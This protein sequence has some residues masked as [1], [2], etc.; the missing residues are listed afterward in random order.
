MSN[1]VEHRRFSKFDAAGRNNKFWNI[2]LYENG[3]VEV[4]FGPQGKDGQHKT[5]PAGHPKSG[6]HGFDKYIKEK[7]GPKKGYTENKVL[8]ATEENGHLSKHALAEKAVKDMSADQ[9]ELRSLIKYFADVN[10]HN[11][12]KA[13]GGKITYDTSSGTFKT[14]QG[15]ITLDQIREA[16]R[17]LNAVGKYAAKNDFSSNRFFASVNPYLSLIPQEGLV[18]QINFSDM[19]GLKGG[20][21]KQSDILDSL[22]SSYA[23]VISQDNKPKADDRQLFNVRL[24]KTTKKEFMTVRQLYQKTRGLHRDV[25]H[26]DVSKV[27]NLTI[28][29]MATG[30]IKQVREMDKKKK[31]GANVMRLLH[32][33]KAAN[34][35]SIL[36]AGF[37]MP[38]KGTSIHI[39]AWMFGPGAY[40]SDQSTK[41]IRYATGAWGGSGAKD[42]KFMFLCDVAMGRYHVPSKNEHW[43]YRL[44]RGYDSCFAKGGKSGVMNNEMIVYT[45][46]Q[47]NPVYILELTPGG[48]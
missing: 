5:F 33:T 44:P 20:L 13:S 24:K 46:G 19:F 37:M 3:D 17:F 6:R 39:T 21:Q 45:I 48:K 30:F 27:F 43:G 26:Y 1:I 4:H 23:T 16:R 8:E 12:Y 32:G 36:K 47:I 28:Q 25:K 29:D 10:A 9:P 42:R 2:T 38:K 34:M 22:E 31:P 35:L 14:T 40:F 11:L 18:R 7:T 15:V 41:S